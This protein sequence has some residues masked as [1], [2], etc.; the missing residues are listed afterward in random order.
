M[1]PSL[2]NESWYYRPG[3]AM[4]D[5]FNSQSKNIGALLSSNQRERLIVPKFQRGY[6]WE[7]KHVEAFWKDITRFQKESA[8]KDGPTKYF[9]GPIV[10]LARSKDAIELLDGQQRLA[11]A[12]ILLSVLRDIARSLVIQEATDFARDTQRLLITKETGT[13]S[14]E[15]GELDKLYF[16]ETIQ[17]DPPKTKTPLLRSNRNIQK[18]RQFLYES[19][20]TAIGGH[21]PQTGLKLLRELGQ[22]L[23]SDLI[24]ACIP[25]DSP[26]DA[27]RIFETLNDRGLRLSVPDLL[28]NYL[29]GAAENEEQQRQ[30]RD[31][32]NEMLEQMGARDINRFLRHMW[33]SKYG[34][35]KSQ[36]L[37]SALKQHIEDKSIRSVDFTRLCAE[38]CESYVY[39]VNHDEEHLGDT[40][41][42]VRSLIRQLEIQ[43]ALPLLLSSYRLFKDSDFDKVVRWLLVFVTR[44]SVISN[45]DSS[46]MESVLFELARD[47]RV[48]MENPEGEA[49]PTQAGSCLVYIKE[50]LEKNAPTDESIRAAVAELILSNEDAKYILS[51]LATRMQT[52]TKEVK[53]HEANLE[54]IFPKKPS[55]EWGDTKELEPLLWHVGNLTILGQRINREVGNKEFSVKCAHYE[56]ATELEMTKRIATEYSKWDAT[57]VVKRAT[58]LASLVTEI[59]NFT[60]PSRV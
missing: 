52:N 47:V 18:A 49:D 53:I 42:H 45:L 5:T 58:S 6:S 37:F 33:V 15:L 25:V 13:F 14:L 23:R 54:H 12:T 59:W 50:T 10:I 48:K 24:L 43:S 55:K 32:W 8:A 36:D 28:L 16:E 35:L 39:L 17:S 26:R 56:K 7:K 19:V 21:G 30:I 46:G 51:R 40:A 2:L 38:E 29:M 22:I 1:T 20:K 31:F 3:L 27:F 57:Q 4:Y 60:N 9:L 11:T 41:V 44:Y 34:D